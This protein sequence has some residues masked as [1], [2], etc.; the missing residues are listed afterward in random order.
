M[1]KDK[2]KLLFSLTKK[3]FTLR[4]F[5]GSGSGG[6]KRNKTLSCIEIIHEDSGASAIGSD[7]RSF[8][9]NKKVAFK[10]LISTEE[11]KKWHKF[12]CAEAMG[13]VISK[14]E[15]LKQW[16]KED[17][18]VIEIKKDGRWCKVNTDYFIEKLEIF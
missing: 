10:R 7:Q 4:P 17:N 9:Q 14:E 18:F 6:Q 2:D 12:K 13:L 15:Q 11:F 5:K 8:Q 1:A 16:L 3:D